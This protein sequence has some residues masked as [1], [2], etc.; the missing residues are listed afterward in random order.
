MWNFIFDALETL[1]A[2]IGEIV[3]IIIDGVMEMFAHVVQ[4]FKG[5]K[6]RKNRDIPF[7]ANKNSEKFREMLDKAPVKDVG[8]FEG[9]YNEDTNEIENY[10]SLEADSLD[11]E[12]ASALGNEP[13]VVL[14]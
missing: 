11:P 8:I 12:I 10:R 2:R 3:S 5:L 13:L 7:I 14:N 1:F 6:L 9:T 4:Y